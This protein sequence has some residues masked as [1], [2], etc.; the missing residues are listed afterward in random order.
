MI[1]PSMQGSMHIPDKNNVPN[2]VNSA[3]H[4]FVVVSADSFQN[5]LYPKKIF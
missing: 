3:F 5:Y 1:E 2:Y 4:A